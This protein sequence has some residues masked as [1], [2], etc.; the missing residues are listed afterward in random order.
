VWAIG[1]DHAM[2]I[3]L[4]QEQQLYVIGSCGGYSCLGF[5]VAERKIC[6]IWNWLCREGDFPSNLEGELYSTKP[7]TL[8][9]YEF[10][11]KLCDEG[12]NFSRKT[13]KRC[14]EE[15][16]PQLIGLEGHRVEITEEGGDKPRRFIVGKST[17]WMPVHL[18][19]AKRNSSGG[20]S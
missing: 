16:S 13:G 1:K 3:S 6:Q 12:H 17:G 9:R 7:G 8:A 19:I 5:D 10:Y 11:M 18:E 4:N 15:L 20:G 2:A 14:E